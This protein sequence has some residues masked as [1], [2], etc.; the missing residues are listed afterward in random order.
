MRFAAPVR[1]QQQ[2]ST[3]LRIFADI[4]NVSRLKKD[5]GDNSDEMPPSHY[6]VVIS[7]GLIFPAL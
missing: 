5:D 2:Q 7:E 3:K 4:T 6:T 1:F